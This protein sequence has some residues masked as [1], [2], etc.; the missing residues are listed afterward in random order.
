MFCEGNQLPEDITCLAVG[1][2][3]S[4]AAC[5]KDI[6]AFSRGKQVNK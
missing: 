6:Y 2:T 5:G 3:F 4:F 1:Q